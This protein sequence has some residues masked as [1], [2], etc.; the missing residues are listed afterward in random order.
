M[1]GG[2]IRGPALPSKRCFVA[3]WLIKVDMN[4]LTRLHGLASKKLLCVVNA[5]TGRMQRALAGS[6][7]RERRPGSGE[8]ADCSR[9]MSVCG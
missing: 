7:G 4:R 3:G 6:H 2:S 8:S 9:Y 1:H 5:W